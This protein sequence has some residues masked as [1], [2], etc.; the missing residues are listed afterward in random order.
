MCP[1]KS[2]YHVFY[3]LLYILYYGCQGV[4]VG[5]KVEVERSAHKM[6]C[7]VGKVKLKRGGHLW[8]CYG[9]GHAMHLVSRQAIHLLAYGIGFGYVLAHQFVVVV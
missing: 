5:G 9:I 4:V 7:A 3:V 2:F 8:P 6:L 1:S